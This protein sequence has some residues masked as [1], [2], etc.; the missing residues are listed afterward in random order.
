M[1]TFH[2]GCLLSAITIRKPNANRAEDMITLSQ[3]ASRLMCNSGTTKGNPS[4][5]P[6]KAQGSKKAEEVREHV[7]GYD[8]QDPDLM[9]Q[10]IY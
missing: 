1:N 10:N 9:F 3:A 2:P 6:S 4:S 8:R 7:R 5:S